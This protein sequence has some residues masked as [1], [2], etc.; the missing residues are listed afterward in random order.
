MTLRRRPSVRPALAA[1]CTAGLVAAL[2]PAAGAMTTG[3]GDGGT[4]TPPPAPSEP[5]FSDTEGSVHADAIELLAAL[6]LLRGFEDGTF[7]PGDPITRGQL[8]SVVARAL[9]LLPV[10]PAEGAEGERVVF[11]DTADSIHR[12]TIQALADAGVTVGFGDGTFR[13]SLA[14]DRAQT[15]SLLARAFGAD[16][17][18]TEC[19]SDLD[20]VGVHADNI[21]AL[22]ARGVLAGL[23]DGTFAPGADV[24]RGQVASIVGRA[25]GLVDPA[26]TEYVLTVLHNNDGESDLLPAEDGSGSLARFGTLLRTLATAGAQGPDRGS[27]AIAAGD[28]FLAGKELQA[29][30]SRPESQPVLDA[31][32][33][34]TLPYDAFVIGN[35]EF[36]FGTD[37]LA[38]F[39]GDF[40]GT[41]PFLSANLGFSDVPDLQALVD[42]GRIRSSTTVTEDGRRIGIVGL[43]TPEL[44]EVS[45]PGSTDIDEDLTAVAQAEVDA[46]RA[47]GAELVVLASH[48]QDIT[49]EQDL[50]GTLSGVDAVVGG[51]GGEDIRDSYPLVALDADGE[52]VP[53]VTVPG[54]YEDVGR[55][56]LALDAEG[57][58]IGFGGGL[59]PVTGLIAEDPF[60]VGNVQMPVEDFL[61]DLET[62]VVAT[63]E[64]PLNGVR[65]DVRSRE[66]N[67]GN[68]LADAFLDTAAGLNDGGDPLVGLQNGGG[69]R[70]DSLIGPG[71]VTAAD[72]FDIAPFDNRVAI[73]DDV[74][75]ADLLAAA[76]HGLEGLPNP[77]GSFAQWGGLEI[78]YDPSAA[79]GERVRSITL[80]DGTPG[81]RGGR[82]RRR[83]AG[84]RHRDDQLPG[85][86]ERRLRR[87]R[88]LRL[89]AAGPVLRP[90]AAGQAA[91]RVAD[92][93][94]R[95][96][97]RRGR[98]RSAHPDAGDP[99]LLT[100]GRTTIGAGGGGPRRRRLR[101]RGT[102]T[103]RGWSFGPPPASSPTGTPPSSSPSSG[104]AG[105][106]RRTS[107]TPGTTGRPTCRSR[108]AARRRRTCGATRG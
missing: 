101:V 100:G 51:G 84:R 19:F 104:T 3:E 71:D 108:T 65:G 107:S 41:V 26:G 6:T 78:T 79:A 86:R 59:V 28:N 2:A 87:V 61:A 76:E 29:S 37:F 54:D 57:E 69:I 88:V 53:V 64:V 18:D 23:G 33:L 60:I 10:E 80:D 97:V 47:D 95:P 5:T 56:T 43:T 52:A 13:P 49:N 20:A 83:R 93:G 99:Q 1:L 90:G 67:V 106:S 81:R 55:L 73:L 50:V 89:H 62:T 98:G 35:H 30:Q 92:R 74:A 27:I 91:G 85:R 96:G 39:I 11:T 4:S 36:D 102:G 48:L 12:D 58:V 15:A 77:A 16:P 32:G 7:A 103:A 44:R 25:L 105:R 40:T 22:A 31:V 46:L 34:N 75:P 63:T 66:T 21:C 72:V 42:A 17:L 38:R 68:L 9:E 24:T 8:A 45:S 82:G 70:N 14:I 94:G